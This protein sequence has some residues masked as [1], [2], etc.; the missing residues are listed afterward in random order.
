[1]CDDPACCDIEGSEVPDDTEIAA[2]HAL[3][4]RALLPSRQALRDQIKPVEFVA[5]RS[6]QQALD[7]ALDDVLD[8]ALTGNRQR[9]QDATV[10][11]VRTLVERYAD[12]RTASLTDDQAARVI[13]GLDDVLARDRILAA[14]LRDDP[15]VV[16]R[17]FLDLCRRAVPPYDAPTCTVLAGLAYASGN[18][19][20]ANVALERAL[21]TDQTYS[22]ALLFRDALHQ[23]LPPELLRQAWRDADGELT[24]K[25]R[26]R[27]TRKKR[28]KAPRRH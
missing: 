19:A 7:R 22:L 3:L 4:G 1:V 5:R 6:M 21:E 13:A 17:L 16:Q 11:L 18:G 26:S 25:P 27:G 15:G 20:L 8:E 9:A 10:Q 12:P 24:H 2:A 23:Q 14:G 28:R